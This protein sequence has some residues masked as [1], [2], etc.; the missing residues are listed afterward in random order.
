MLNS[1]VCG[2]R[3]RKQTLCMALMLLVSLVTAPSFSAQAATL[4]TVFALD[5]HQTSSGVVEGDGANAGYLFGTTSD[6]SLTYGGA[7]FKVPVGG[8]SP[9]TVYQLDSTNG[10][11]P[12]ATLLLSTDHNLYGTTRYAPRIGNQTAYGGGTIFRIAQDGSGFTTLYTFPGDAT[13]GFPNGAY[14]DRA[15]IEDANYLY[16]IATAGGTNGTGTVF[17][18][19]KSDGVFQV[20]HQF[21]ALNA[22]GSSSEGA[23]PSSSLTLASNGRLYG[24][25]AG[26]GANLKT[27]L[28]SSGNA[29]TAGTGTIYSLNIDGTGFQTVYQFS[30]L[31]KRTTDPNDSTISLTYNADGAQPNGNLLEVSPGILLGTTTDGGNPSANP[32]PPPNPVSGY[33]TVFRFV[34]NDA[35]L[36]TLYAFDNTNGAAP[37]GSLVKDRN[38]TSVYGLTSSGSATTSPTHQYGNVFHLTPTAANFVSASFTFDYPLAFTDGSQLNQGLIQA[39]NGDLFFSTAYGNGCTAL[40]GTGYGAVLRYSVTTGASSAGYSNCTAPTTSSG[41]GA[42]SLGWLCLL[43]ALGLVPVVRRRVNV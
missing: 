27:S 41:G 21:A 1:T 34:I 16:G 8:G 26:G 9:Q 32:S 6:V 17:R 28:D 36:T 19:R 18:V 25:T 10:Y 33:G 43:A 30:A 31:D 24:V 2:H 14:P 22:N 11:S 15:L 23:T 39:S 12:Q 42:L 4:S 7:I 20:L 40:N 35:T 3:A 37:F 38:S 5:L 13:S 29:V